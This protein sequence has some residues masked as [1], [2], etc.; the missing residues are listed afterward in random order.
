MSSELN[1]NLF[2]TCTDN[3]IR[4]V[5]AELQTFEFQYLPSRDSAEH[6]VQLGKRIQHLEDQR[7]TCGC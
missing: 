3:H 7:S 2:Y 6:T 1:C 4:Y 5:S